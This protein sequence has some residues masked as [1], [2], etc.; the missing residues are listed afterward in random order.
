MVPCRIQADL[1]HV[2]LTNH[3]C[4][5]ENGTT[6]C[7]TSTAWEIAHQTLNSI[8]NNYLHINLTWSIIQSIIHYVCFKFTDSPCDDWENICIC[9]YIYI[10]CLIIIK[11]EVWTIS[12]CLGSG[13]ETMVCAV[14][15][16]IFLWRISNPQLYV[17]IPNLYS[18]GF[19]YHW[20]G[21]LKFSKTKH[22]AAVFISI[23]LCLTCR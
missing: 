23:G 11:S 10:L 14:C 22:N 13:Y 6:S 16:S 8:F 1:K 4:V 3:N 5:Y 19:V 7:P 17:Q 18:D 20:N 15:L 2:Y 21:Q 9:I 12:H